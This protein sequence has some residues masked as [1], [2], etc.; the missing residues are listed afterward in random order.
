MPLLR[1]GFD[2]NPNE[3]SS[4][5]APLRLG[6][7]KLAAARC[8]RFR[9]AATGSAAR[10]NSATHTAAANFRLSLPA[11]QN[12]C[13]AANQPKNLHRRLDCFRT[14]VNFLFSAFLDRS[15]DERRRAR[16]L[17]V[18]YQTGI[19]FSPQRHGGTEI[20]INFLCAS[21]SLW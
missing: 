10:P 21:V 14:N 6:E 4:S 3:N 20:F 13:A 7:S 15:A 16:L 9:R 19:I 11:L 5:A 17:D 12:N 1:R 18:F 8:C 2:T